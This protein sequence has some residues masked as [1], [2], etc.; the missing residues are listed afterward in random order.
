MKRAVLADHNATHHA[1]LKAL[2]ATANIQENIF[3][4]G[5]ATA[6][7]LSSPEILEIFLA[8]YPRHGFRPSDKTNFETSP[9]WRHFITLIQRPMATHRMKFSFGKHTHHPSPAGVHINAKLHLLSASGFKLLNESSAELE[10][11]W[12]RETAVPNRAAKRIVFNLVRAGVSVS[13]QLVRNMLNTR[14]VV[15]A[16][17][18]MICRAIHGLSRDDVDVRVDVEAAMFSGAAPARGGSKSCRKFM[19]ECS[20]LNAA[21]E[22]T[23]GGAT[24]GAMVFLIDIM[25]GMKLEEVGEE[26]PMGAWLLANKTSGISRVVERGWVEW[27]EEAGRQVA[28]RLKGVKDGAW[29]KDI[30]L[31]P[32]V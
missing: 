8:S 29:G 11:L 15:R 16:D 13:R 12:R 7:L 28:G 30:P 31:E 10:T 19:F 9:V 20:V 27:W 17:D 18:E 22:K 5:W 23:K 2:V 25:Q 26:E 6:L 24:N 3:I 4:Q 32:K 14:P 21:V 1:V